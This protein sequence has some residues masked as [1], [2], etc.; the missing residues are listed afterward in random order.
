MQKRASSSVRPQKFM[1]KDEQNVNDE[2]DL[3]V[4]K[5]RRERGKLLGT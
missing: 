1:G 3:F 4:N 5:F 2:K